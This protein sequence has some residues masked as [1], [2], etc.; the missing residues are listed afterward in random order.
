MG[1]NPQT[2]P[3]CT[4]QPPEDNRI[5]DICCQDQWRTQGKTCGRLI[6]HSRPHGENLFMSSI[7]E[8]LKA[9]QIP[10]GAQHPRGMGI[11]TTYQVSLK[12]F[13]S[14]GQT[15]SAEQADS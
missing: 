14:F 6:S 13:Q 11:V 12:H 2:D 15:L 10:W 1:F 3:K 9:C 7:P 4:S 5:L 8:T